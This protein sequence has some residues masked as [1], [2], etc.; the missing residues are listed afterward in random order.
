M[1]DVLRSRRSGSQDEQPADLPSVTSETHPIRLSWIAHSTQDEDESF[2]FAVSYC[3]GKVV[4]SWRRC[5]AIDLAGLREH[6]GI[7]RIVCLLNDAELR[8]RYPRMHSCV[9]M[10]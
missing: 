10:L 1:L 4:G 7:T 2:Y 9:S 8:V 5:L 6:H 3:P